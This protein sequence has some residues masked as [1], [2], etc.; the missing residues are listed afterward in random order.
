[1]T[2]T[3]SRTVTPKL[4]PK[5]KLNKGKKAKLLPW[6]KRKRTKRTVRSRRKTRRT[7]RKRPRTRPKRGN[8]EDKH[9]NFY[10]GFYEIHK[11]I[12][13]MYKSFISHISN[14]E[15]MEV[16]FE[17]FKVLIVKEVFIDGSGSFP[18][19]FSSYE[20][21]NCKWTLCELFKLFTL[22]LLE[23]V[24]SGV[25]QTVFHNSILVK[26]DFVNLNRGVFN[27]ILVFP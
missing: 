5:L 12:Y 22:K 24:S 17:L 16:F 10:R 7:E 20:K 14:V 19:T 1:M 18:S 9:S 21:Y 8:D 15:V 13:R 26:L 3:S 2:M 11:H 27:V 6:P 25:L 23:L 4:W